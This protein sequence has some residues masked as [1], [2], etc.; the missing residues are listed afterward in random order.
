MAD[1]PPYPE[2]NPDPDA[3]PDRDPTTGAPRWVKVFGIIGLLVLLLGVILMVMGG[4]GPG[5]QHARRP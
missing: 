1:Q 4:H 3:G 2:T 5:R